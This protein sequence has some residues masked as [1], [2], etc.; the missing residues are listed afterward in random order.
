VI[1]FLLAKNYYLTALEL[2]VESQQAGRAEEVDELRL[3]FGDTDKFPPE[4][5]AKHQ[6]TN[7]Q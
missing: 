4:E 2:L 5:L 7:G 3:F 1:Q 6:S